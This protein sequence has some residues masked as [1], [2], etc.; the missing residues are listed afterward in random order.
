MYDLGNEGRPATGRRGRVFLA[1]F[2]AGRAWN[3][4]MRGA[5]AAGNIAECARR[6]LYLAEG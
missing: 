2:L 5:A 1:V 4:K 6:R 3:A